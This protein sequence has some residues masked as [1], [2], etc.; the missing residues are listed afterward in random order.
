MPKAPRTTFM[1]SSCGESQ[2]R[3]FGRCPSCDAWNTAVE[4]PSAKP[5]R[6]SRTWV[7]GGADRAR[8]RSL[9]EVEV[10]AHRRA[11]TGIGELD[12]VLGG[13]MV[14]GG[15]VLVGG[16]PGIG[17]STL[18]L[19]A[20]RE[21]AAAGG[22]VLLVAGEE[23]E[24]Q[25]RMRAER[26]GPV[27]DELLVVC[28]TDLDAAL[29]HA[30]DA[31]PALVIVDSIQTMMQPAVEGG[32]GS[33]T[34]VRE[35]GLA[36]LQYAKSSGTPVFLVG[37]VTKDGAVAGP[38]VLEHMV[39]AV[40][41]LEGERYQHYRVLRAA[42]NRF[43]STQELGVFE[44][45][46]TGLAEVDNPSA[47]F[48]PGAGREE[49][50]AAVVASLEGS[51]PLVVEVQALVSTSFY[52]TPQRVTSGLDARR[53]SVLLAV[54]ERRAGLRL[55]RHD[56][57]TSVAGGLALSEPGTDLGAALAVA[58]SYRSRPVLARTLVVGEVA[59]SGEVRRVP[60]LDARVREAAQLG[61]VRAGVPA[62]QADEARGAGIEI[63]AIDTV[64]DAV[65]QL[66]GARVAPPPRE[67]AEGPPEA[68][69]RGAPVRGGGR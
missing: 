38:R 46:G 28:E 67:P 62:S 30:A 12:R 17:K 64:R 58:S 29:A 43:G 53:L 5:G 26:L 60:R 20:A 50:G 48:L 24:E 61:F 6:P 22:P 16:D 1:C 7:Q 31:R 13:G 59:L 32:A 55:G 68:R 18:L 34:Q 49:P 36:L 35:C 40:L 23:S 65:D 54:L 10:R 42:K 47:A 39:D 63:V 9:G 33:V 57:F 27:P 19:Q 25:I 37:H 56:V 21:V 45:T 44:M 69:R 15:L 2:P 41:Y 8:V 4:A 51:R 14:P 3:W 66:L 52:G 11:A